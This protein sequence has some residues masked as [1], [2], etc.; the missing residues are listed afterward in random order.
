MVRRVKATEKKAQTTSARARNDMPTRRRS[1]LVAQLKQLTS[2]VVIP[3]QKE[4]AD[5]LADNGGL[6][7]LLPD[8]CRDVRAAFGPKVELSLQLYRD[9]EIDDRY[10]TLYVRQEKYDQDILKQIEA[11]S[12]AFDDRLQEAPGYFLLATDF[13]RPERGRNLL[14]PLA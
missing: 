10:L 14:A 11:V 5:Y 12:K 13:R 1:K 3:K 8:I 2:V 6:A 9:P 4:V 7:R